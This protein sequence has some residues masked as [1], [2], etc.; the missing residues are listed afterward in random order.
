M[1]RRS[2]RDLVRGDEKNRDENQKASRKVAQDGE[3]R[4]YFR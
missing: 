3:R 2:G 4:L 1:R